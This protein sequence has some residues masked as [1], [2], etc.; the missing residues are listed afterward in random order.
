MPPL[1][2]GEL[3]SLTATA[4]GAQAGDTESGTACTPLTLM[5][6]VKSY[7]LYVGDN[8]MNIQFKRIEPHMVSSLVICI[9]DY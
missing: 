5:K 9:I 7:L 2:M 8:K 1:Q 6:Q 4:Q 3:L